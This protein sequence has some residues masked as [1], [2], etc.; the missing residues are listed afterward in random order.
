MYFFYSEQMFSH[1]RTMQNYFN[2]L[3]DFGGLT[4]IL[5]YS[6]GI[7]VMYAN[8][9]F[10]RAKHSKSMYFKSDPEDMTFK[11][12]LQ[13]SISSKLSDIKK[14][15]CC[16]PF[17]TYTKEDQYLKD[18]TQRLKM[19]YNWFKF[20]QEHN[21]MK[22]TFSILF[23]KKMIDQSDINEARRI[24]MDKLTIPEPS[25]DDTVQYLQDRDKQHK[26]W[27]CFMEED[28]HESVAANNGAKYKNGK[29]VSMPGY[30]DD[31]AYSKSSSKGKKSTKKRRSRES[32]KN[33]KKSGRYSDDGHSEGE[34][35]GN[36]YD[37]KPD[38]YDH[39][40]NQKVNQYDSN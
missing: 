21:K 4:E 13:F 3:S 20:L 16:K 22:A 29:L 38:R 5:V 32:S 1:S 14:M 25:D 15:V 39:L 24:Y 31:D 23:N 12:N 33:K 30:G 18:A 6:V 27:Y 8:K 26:Y 37:E 2:I 17:M 9:R 36:I 40:Y 28:E 10:E 7:F 19:D 34:G 35:G 11:E